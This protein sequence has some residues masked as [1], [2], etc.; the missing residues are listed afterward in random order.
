M[1]NVM[2]RAATILI[3]VL[4]VPVHA[5]ADGT[6]TLCNLDNQVGPVMGPLPA[7]NLRDALAGGG[8]ITFRCPPNTVMKLTTAHLVARAFTLDGGNNI[9]L[10]G[11]GTT[12]FLESNGGNFQ[13]ALRD[14]EIRNTRIPTEIVLRPG[15]ATSTVVSNGASLTLDNVTVVGV[16]NAFQ[17]TSITAS[18]GLFRGNRGPVMRGQTVSVDGA[19]F[20]DN[21]GAPITNLSRAIRVGNFPQEPVPIPGVLTIVNTVFEKNRHVDWTGALTIKGSTFSFNGRSERAGGALAID[22]AAT[23][24]KTI[25][26]GNTAVNGGAIITTGGGL[27]LRRVVFESN[28]ATGDGGAVYADNTT[29]PPSTITVSA[30]SF[31]LNSAARG[32]AV[33]LEA[34]STGRV[35]LNGQAVTFAA[36]T[37][38][39]EGGAIHAGAGGV[40][41]LRALLVSNHSGTVGSAVFAV[42]PET[43]PSLFANALL[44]RNKADQGF[45]L[46]I[47]SAK[48]LNVTAADNTGSMLVQPTSIPGGGAG[49]VFMVNTVLSSGS[50]RNCE[51]A[52]GA[53]PPEDGG[54]NIQ[55]PD[56]TCGGFP[57]ADPQIDTHGVPAPGSLVQS[58]GIDSVCVNTPIGRRDLYGHHRPQ[59]QHCTIGAVEGT[60]E[61]EALVELH[62]VREVPAGLQELLHLLTPK[63]QN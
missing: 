1:M 51:V 3:A 56:S 60:L 16:S 22:G 61:R 50:G 49:S 43:S 53:A 27:S 42:G 45:A 46:V 62:A 38:A 44:I 20:D 37:A 23:I 21:D 36:N 2:I 28:R 30:S 33:L 13:I 48:L 35:L 7:L 55:F 54:A 39:S 8:R 47:G 10:D 32:G 25:F 12:N 11:G 17:A 24:S 57:V 18:G 52:P 40:S 14:L 63:P 58:A 59:G 9:T 41:L 31:R 4:S 26:S 34:K 29:N 5:L 19:R 6:V 15:F